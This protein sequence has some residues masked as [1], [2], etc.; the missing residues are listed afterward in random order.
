MSVNQYN[1]NNQLTDAKKQTAA[2]DM[3]SSVCYVVFE[4]TV[5][6]VDPARLKQLL[7]PK[8]HFAEVSLKHQTDVFLTM[9]NKRERGEGCYSVELGNQ[10]SYYFDTANRLTRRRT[11]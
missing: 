4:E 6:H 9:G 8:I 5:I 1:L 3:K 10:T 7:K 11:N 2:P